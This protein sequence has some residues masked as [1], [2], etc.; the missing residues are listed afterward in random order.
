MAARQQHR[1]FEQYPLTGSAVVDGQQVSTP[2]HIYDGSIVFMG[3]TADATAARHLLRDE[4]LT[5]ILDTQGNALMALWL[6]DFTEAN[7]GAH[8]EL[9]ISLFAAYTPQPA[10]PAHPFAIYRLL[11]LNPATMMVCH[12]LWNN[13]ALV[14]NYNREVL[15]LDA[16][17]S[18]SQIETLPT[19]RRR[20]FRVSDAANGQAIAE[21][22][23]HEPG[24]QNARTL[25]ELSAHLGLKGLLNMTR[26]PFIHVPVINTVNERLADNQIAHTYTRADRQ[27]IRRFDPAADRLSI[28]HETYAPLRFRP[29][30]VQHGYGVRFVYLLPQPF[31]QPY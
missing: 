28:Q 14:V 31:S 2:Y 6:C 17:L 29:S 27:I 10:V 16:R 26:N 20:R 12:G 4:R 5:P 21:G 9:Q 19:P 30:F 1:L 13:T 7:L 25:W 11:S 18:A 3:G 22:E 8:H 15:G 23:L 24:Q